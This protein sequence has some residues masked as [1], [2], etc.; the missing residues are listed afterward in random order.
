MILGKQGTWRFIIHAQS[1]ILMHTVLRSEG[2][3]M[4]IAA[5]K[6]CLQGCELARTPE[7]EEF[8]R[9]QCRDWNSREFASWLDI[10]APKR[11][12]TGGVTE[13]SGWDE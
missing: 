6:H 12:K 4:I 10:Q 11:R 7:C 3:E 13:S 9:L 2:Y 8:C 1:L 5:Q